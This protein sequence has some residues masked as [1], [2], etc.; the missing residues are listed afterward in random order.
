VQQIKQGVA[1]S[2]GRSSQDICGVLATDE[3]GYF[4]G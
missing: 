4:D 2:G 1:A 3:E